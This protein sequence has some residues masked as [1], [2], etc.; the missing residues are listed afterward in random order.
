MAEMYHKH[1]LKQSI[2]L[3]PDKAFK[4]IIQC[5]LYKKQI[6]HEISTM[7]RPLTYYGNPV[8]REKG[9]TV[10][11]F[12]SDLKA[13]VEDMI[14]TMYAEEGIG[15]AAQ[16]IG[17]AQQICVVDVRPPK[18][19]EIH[20]NYSY[21]GKSTPLDLFM[22]L[23]IINPKISITDSCESLYQE[24]C[25]SFP[26]ILGDV[27]RAKAVSCQFQDTD[28]NSHT[29]E[30]D[31]LLARCILHEVDHLNGILFIDT[32]KKKD[33]QKNLPRIKQLRRSYK[34]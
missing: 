28:G 18:D 10:D 34:S 20:F 12:D 14:E 26:N 8:L 13:L 23:A 21:D 29:I 17:I 33:L 7:E 19:S 3:F 9:S 5:T 30:A 6:S 32:M 27:S 24:G 16:Q 2:T 15:L 25:L 4:K 31:G 1:R 11:L 22:P